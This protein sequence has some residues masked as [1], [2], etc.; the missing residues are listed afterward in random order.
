MLTTKQKI[1][2][3]RGA[4]RVVK[5]LRGL[6][7]R[8]M[9][10]EFRR[11][12]IT[13]QL[14]L[15]EGIDFAIYCM[16][17]FEPETVRF[18]SKLIRPDN[19]VFDVGANIGAHTLHFAQLVGP[20]GQVYAFEPTESAFGKLSRNLALNP[21]LGPRVRVHHAF[22]SN[23][24]DHTI[25]EA[26]Y[27]SWPLHRSGN[28]HAKHLGALQRV[29]EPQ[30]ICLD[31]LVESTGL[32]RLDLMKLDVDGNEIKV[33]KGCE[34]LLE[35]FHPKV[36]AEIAPYVI[37]EQGYDMEDFWLPFRRNGYRMRTLDKAT[38]IPLETAFFERTYPHYSSVNVLLF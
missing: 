25:P 34:R 4:N 27:S 8:N 12:G 7:H 28:L 5:C 17:S 26:I 21:T 33:L 30:L 37:A 14:D 3:A 24:A 32:K 15:N 29:G 35:Q 31:Q 9:E 20:G 36:L 6:T 16:G 11:G 19:V 1:A 10:G 23:A 13:W 38:E 22:C 18:Y 2:L